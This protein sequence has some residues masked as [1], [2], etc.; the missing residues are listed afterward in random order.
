MNL[1]FRDI[2]SSGIRG[3]AARHALGAT[4]AVAS[5]FRGIG[6][7]VAAMTLFACI[8]AGASFAIYAAP[9]SN[10]T[11]PASSADASNFAYA[12]PLTSTSSP[13]KVSVTV[14]PKNPS[15]PANGRQKFF[16]DVVGGAT[17]EVTWMVNGVPG[18]APSIGTIDEAGNYQAPAGEPGSIKASIVA[19]SKEDPL[20]SGTT[21]ASVAAPTESGDVYYVAPNGDDN[22]TGRA[23]APWRTIQHAVDSVPAGAT[24]QLA[25]GTYNELVTVTKSGSA[26]AGFITVTSVAGQKATLD[27]TGLTGSPGN[28]GLITLRDVSYVR[29]KGLEL[30]EFESDSADRVPVGIYVEGSGNHIEIR[31][32][33]IHGIRTTLDT[34]AGNAF[35]LAVYGAGRTPISDLIIDGNML[36]DLILGYSESLS[37]NGNVTSWQVT[38]NT[39]HDNNNIGIDAIGL[40]KTAPVNDQ[41]RNGWIAENDIYNITSVQN[42]AYDNTPAAGGIYVDGGTHITIDRNRIRAADLGIELASEHG[43]KL[44]S[45]IAVRNNIIQDS[46]V[47]GLSI[48]GY[49][50]TAGGTEYCS[51]INNTFV[52]N[53]TSTSGS[54]EFQIQYNSSDNWVANNIFYANDQG[55]FLSSYAA[56]AWIPAMFENNIYFTTGGD[57]AATWVWKGTTYV[58]LDSFQQG[59]KAAV[60]GLMA[61][62]LFVNAAPYPFGISPNSQAVAYGV[63]KGVA[64]QG[65]LDYAGAPR[66]SAD[67]AI[68]VGALQH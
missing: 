7:S 28:Q 35:G 59:S 58:T 13:G 42:P 16:A 22:S 31:D 36:H 50:A 5:V 32:N 39:I 65:L 34:S 57:S 10:T 40:E 43:N 64:A 17:R 60:R 44:S 67:G 21:S 51:V 26:S 45:Y 33:E 19:V 2:G 54:G 53:D 11:K 38:R 63:N 23:E 46:V 24:I 4:V 14:S 48:G 3:S 20:S 37:V 12:F 47:T 68:D 29:I 41:A 30:K 55:L 61:D 49:K 1:Y 18:G 56:N 52:N 66:T 9:E 6:N 15:L 62:P 25:G 8:G 27:G